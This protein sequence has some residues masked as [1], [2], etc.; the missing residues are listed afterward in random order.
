MKTEQNNQYEE[1]RFSMRLLFKVIS[2]FM[3]TLIGIYIIC[4]FIYREWSGAMNRKHYYND[5]TSI[6]L[7][8]LRVYEEEQLN[9]YGYID[10]ERGT[11]R[12]PIDEAMNR[13]IK[14]KNR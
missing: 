12:I 2:I 10:R 11:V 1:D 8:H 7:K 14:E 5:N 6:E 9:T 3:V 4:F 13:L